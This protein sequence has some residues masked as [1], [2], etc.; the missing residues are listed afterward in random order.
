MRTSAI[1]IVLSLLS[2]SV[3]TA[4]DYLPLQ[5]GNQ[6]TFAMTGGAQMTVQVTGFEDVGTVRC[7]IVETTMGQQKSQEYLAVDT[8]GVK[9]YLG[10]TQGQEFRYDPPI[11]RIQLP[12]QEGDSWT[13]TVK[14]AGMSLTTT[15]QS[16][17]RERL[18][19]PA[20]VFDCIKV[21]SVVNGVPGQGSAMSVSYYADGI[22]P[23]KQIFQAGGQQ[24]VAVLFSTSVKPGKKPPAGP[25][26]PVRKPQATPKTPDPA[27]AQTPAKARCPQC[28]A[29]VDPKAK[30]CPQCGYNL[31]TP[32]VTAE[33]NRPAAPAATGP[34]ALEKYQSP[35][36]KVLLYRP[37]SWKVDQ[38]DMFGP[39]TYGVTVLE[40]Q[41]NAVVLFITFAVGPEIK[42]SVALAA[43]CIAALRTTYP[44][45]QATNVNSTADRQRTILDLG[46]TDK[47]EKGTGHGYFF[48][49]ANTG[50]VY[51]LLAKAKLWNELRPTLTTVAANLAYTPQGVAAVQEQGRKAATQ[52]SAVAPASGP[53]GMIQR[54]MQ[55]AGKQI[56]LRP[57]AL[58]DQSLSLQIPEGWTLEGA[59]V[60]YAVV[61]DA[62][63]RSYGLGSLWLTIL[64][65]QFSVPGVINVPYQPP[66]QALKIVLESGKS[67]RDVQVLDECP[68]EQAVPE[69]A[70]LIQ[71]LRAQGSQVDARLIHAQFRNV[72][73]GQLCRGLF[74]VMC[75]IKPIS[76]V[77]QVSL[78]GSWA[79]QSEYEEWLPLFLRIEKTAQVNQQWMG[80]EMQNQALRQQQLNRNLQKSIAE[81]NRAFDDYMNTVRD[82]SRSR[83]YISHMWS[84]TTLGQGS[85]VAES[86]GAKVYQTDSWG[87]EGPEGRIDSR[88]YNTTNFTGEN[89]WTGRQMELIDTRAEYERYIANP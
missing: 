5:E 22:G 66:P 76:P 45:L 62:Q 36:G 31:A 3:T 41:E 38:G 18:D 12:Y 17:G 64:P 19:T 24:M 63:I 71:Q 86:E 6:W 50:S 21:Y 81:S 47:G 13:S 8:E 16:I 40:P 46:L 49:T 39:G 44:D 82:G 52:P 55:Q 7:A 84:Q 1:A 67:T 70:Q 61:N 60:Q 14:Q 80:Q 78:Q 32:V 35:D 68:V 2:A 33:P 83:D 58:A 48:H 77:W 42:D 20:G 28:G 37:Q 29:P 43:R 88:A 51:L 89:P 79:P 56:P 27:Q 23:V 73:T 26:K 75:S 34:A 11:L 10:K 69:M 65:T 54:A 85:W 53:A 87:L 72:P 59:K 57:A 9:A 74:C 15:F 25:A 4:A 30:F